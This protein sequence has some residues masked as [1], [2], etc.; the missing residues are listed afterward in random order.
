MLKKEG[1]GKKRREEG[2]KTGEAGWRGQGKG[3]ALLAIPETEFGGYQNLL[4]LV[5]TRRPPVITFVSPTPSS[6]RGARDV[7]KEPRESW[8]MGL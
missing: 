6:E 3:A 4:V 7:A 8:G 1:R 5:I 2:L